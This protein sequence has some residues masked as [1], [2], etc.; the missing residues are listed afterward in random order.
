M[1]DF[2]LL[3]KLR[4]EYEC[5]PCNS[6]HDAVCKHTNTIS[7]QFTVI[8]S[9]CGQELIN[10]EMKCSIDQM[11]SSTSE[12]KQHDKNIFKDVE[13]F[14]FNE[15]IVNK[16]NLIYKKVTFDKTKRG[17]R[18]KSIILACIFFSHRINNVN[19]TYEKLL[20]MFEID[21]KIGNDGLNIVTLNIP[22]EMNVNYSSGSQYLVVLDEIMDKFSATPDQRKQVN[23]LYYKIKGKSTELNRCRIHSLASAIFYYWIKNYSNI[24]IS[25]ETYSDIVK[26]RVL[27]ISKIYNEI[28]KII[29]K[30]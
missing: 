11:Y 18:R 26:L 6:V 16:A 19:I 24:K 14:N 23:E 13:S 29:E 2:D 20:E 28:H 4:D 1:T 15:N 30:L 27:T 8:C 3:T 5:D 25:I 12:R 9:D 7:E 17:D 10:N 22:K 21:R